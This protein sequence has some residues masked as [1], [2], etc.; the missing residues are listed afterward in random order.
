MFKIIVTVSFCIGSIFISC[1]QTA[2]PATVSENIQARVDNRTNIGIVV[3]ILDTNGPRYF[4]YGVKSL[5]SHEAINEYSVF[6]IGSISKTFTGILLADKVIKGEVKLNDPLQKYLPEGV[7]APV[8]N[9]TFITLAHLSNHTSSLPYMPGNHNPGNPNNP[10]AD[11]SV[12]QL[13]DFLTNYKLTRDVGSQYEYS[14][15][16]AG[17]LGHI[18]AAKTGISYEQLMVNV[19]AKPLNLQHT[20]IT[21]TPDMK[22]NL[23]TGYVGETEV[24]N[25]DLPALAGAGAIR[26]T[27]VDMMKY[28]SANIGLVKT[29]L[30]SAMQLSHQNSRV[31]GAMPK[32][33]LGWH[34]AT[35]GNQ[36]V[37]WHNGGT[38]GY[39]TFIGFIKG[40]NKAVV[41]LSNSNTSID[42][43]GRHLLNPTSPLKVID[44][45]I[46]VE[47]AVLQR[48]V[49]KYELAPGFILTVS[50]T[51]SQLKAQLTGQQEFPVFA[52]SDN[53]FYYKVVEAQLTFN[54][55]SSGIVESV[56]L[57]QGGQKIVG[58]RLQE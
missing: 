58:K 46:T 16:A 38:G 14:N 8:R 39:R 48:Y 53:V 11:Y 54:Q 29:E 42:D 13:Y 30:N 18:L 43:I 51:D 57:D 55:N 20:R 17:L 41:V 22:I 26:S 36:E 33:G 21:L 1:A 10:F 23:A 28:L 45:P 37:I 35:M 6:E 44:K 4:S 47:A 31:E 2:L 34:L 3:G 19:I 5:K 32:V 24:E 40:E 52:K 12:T 56:T 9:E 15:Y 7:N 25:W 50:K 27:A 49:G